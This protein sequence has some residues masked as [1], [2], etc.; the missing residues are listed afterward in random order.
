MIVQEFLFSFCN[1]SRN[2]IKMKIQYIIAGERCK[3]VGRQF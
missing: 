2:C 3:T 1:Y